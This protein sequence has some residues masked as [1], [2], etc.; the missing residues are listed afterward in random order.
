MNLDHFLTFGELLNKSPALLTFLTTEF[1]IVIEITPAIGHFRVYFKPLLQDESS[2][3][4]EFN[5]HRNEP[6]DETYFHC[7]QM[8]GFARGLVLTQWQK[9]T[10]KWSIE[11]LELVYRFEQDFVD[12]V[13]IG[14]IGE[15][16]R[17]Q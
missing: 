1:S 6:A 9:A 17:P 2:C 10:R 16:R 4:K 12:N 3:K 5:L 14:S 8:N 7:F 13:K 15:T 11:I